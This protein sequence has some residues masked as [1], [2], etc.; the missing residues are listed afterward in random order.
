VNVQHL[1]AIEQM[2]RNDATVG[3]DNAEKILSGVFF[4]PHEIMRA[5]DAVR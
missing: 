5:L 3:N 1:H 2:R 4:Q